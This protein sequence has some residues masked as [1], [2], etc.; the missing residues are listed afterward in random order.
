MVFE[1]SLRGVCVAAQSAE[2][3][4]GDGDVSYVCFLARVCCICGFS[5]A[6]T[7]YLLWDDGSNASDSDERSMGGSTGGEFCDVDYA[8]CGAVFYEFVVFSGLRCGE[9]KFDVWG[10]IERIVL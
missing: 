8:I 5:Y 9:W 7:V 1:T 10:L 6:E 3:D 4:G 2:G